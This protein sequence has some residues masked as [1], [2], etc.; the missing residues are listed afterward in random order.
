MGFFNN[1]EM[2]IL[3]NRR[4]GLIRLSILII[5]LIT[6]SCKKD[7]PGIPPHIEFIKQA[8]YIWS[9]TTLQ[10]GT[11]VK[12]GVV[13]SKTNANITYFNIVVSKNGTSQIAIDSGMNTSNFSYNYLI[14]YQGLSDVETWTFMTMDED[15]NKSS[16]SLTIKRSVVTNWGAVKS[17]NSILLGAQNNT[18]N[19]SFLSLNSGNTFLLDQA[20]LNQ[21]SIDIIYYY[22]PSPNYY[23]A[24]LSS[25]LETQAPDFFT[26]TYGISNWTTK[27]VTMYSLTSIS[28][29]QF[30]QI[31]NDSL[32]I[33]SYP[34]AGSTK[35]SKFMQADQVISFKDIAGKYGLIKV[36]SVNGT[37]AGTAELSIKIQE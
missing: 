22:G 9:D 1:G 29:T 13:G 32:L 30:D 26:G 17:F 31:T 10:I 35:K 27:H 15:R 24:T 34:L 36:V 6:M 2:H 4:R 7:E 11:Q 23:N 3:S 25:P 14:N 8:G 37:D 18:V 33:V 12:I 5:V 28:P 16:I 21:D 19:G 20:F